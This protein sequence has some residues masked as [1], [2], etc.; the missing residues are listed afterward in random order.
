MDRARTP[1]CPDVCCSSPHAGLLEE[2]PS[3]EPLQRG[4]LC[5]GAVVAARGGS[6]ARRC[7]ADQHLRLLVG[8]TLERAGG[9]CLHGRGNVQRGRPRAQNLPRECLLNPL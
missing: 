7:L 9:A 3:R 4:S 5:G 6:R 1:P 8:G 2:P